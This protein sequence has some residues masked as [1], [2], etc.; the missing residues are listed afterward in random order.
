MDRQKR[1]YE[2]EILPLSTRI[3]PVR[4]LQFICLLACLLAACSRGSNDKA[5]SGKQSSGPVIV[6]QDQIRSGPDY[7]VRLRS[8]NEL[9]SGILQINYP[10]GSKAKQIEYQKGKPNGKHREW[11]ENQQLLLERTL[12]NGIPHGEHTEWYPNGK[13][14]AQGKWDMGEPA[15][16][17]TEWTEDGKEEWLITFENGKPASRKIVRND[18]LTLPETDRKYLWDTE[19]HGTL[20]GKYGFGPFKAA[21]AEQDRKKLIA[22]LAKNFEGQLPKNIQPA[23]RILGTT[24]AHRLDFTDDELNQVDANEFG[25]WLLERMSAFKGKPSIKASMITFAPVDR[26]TITG[27]WNGLCKMHAWGQRA[28]GGPLEI[29]IYLDLTITQP[30]EENLHAGGWIERAAVKRIK[31]AESSHPL[32][33]DIARESGLNP[34]VL[35]D[36]WKLDPKQTALNTGGMYFCD[37]NHDG[38]MDF[39]LTDIALP[40]GLTLYQG[41]AGGKFEDVTTSSGLD[42]LQDGV[43]TITDL[44]GDGWEDIVFVNG[45]VYQNLE[46]KRFRNVTSQTNLG[47]IA[48]LLNVSASS[49]IAVADYDRD[50]KTDLYIFRVD[51]HPTKGSWIDGQIGS[52]A[53]NQLLRNLGNWKFEDVTETTRTDGG[54]RSTFSS[55]WLDADN[56]GWPDIY[57]INEYGNGILLLNQGANKPFRARELIDRA[58]DFGSM[59]LSTGDINNDGNID[60]YVASMY[61]KAGSRVIGN[62]RPN[63][64]NDEVM[65]KLRRMVAGSQLYQNLGSDKFEPIGK[66]VDV[67]SVGWAYGPT[68]ADLDNDGHLDIYAPCGFIS[69]TREKP[70]G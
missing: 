3:F 8:N 37:W 70:D 62:L 17:M 13:K 5:K 24:K 26:S 68:L 9:L 2:I 69:R 4:T 21:L 52:K 35:H 27:S 63:A 29:Y 60:I 58:A 45:D 19:H 33:S 1:Y 41:M 50:G 18:D 14:K 6:T 23:S 22:L 43:G 15:G 12:A 55:A 64:Y 48:D 39:V 20:L 46:G 67:V 56:N 54:R 51:S 11:S 16:Q 61:S 10:D 47:K 28:D 49:N 65:A 66:A 32:M 25:D 7:L 34:D 36:N 44:D 53:A 38:H 30:T 31:H 57:V 59:G 40:R 42:K